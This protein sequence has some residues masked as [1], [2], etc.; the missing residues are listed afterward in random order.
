MMEPCLSRADRKQSMSFLGLFA[1]AIASSLGWAAREG[2]RSGDGV[3]DRACRGETPFRASRWLSTSMLPLPQAPLLRLSLLVERNDRGEREAVARRPTKGLLRS[4]KRRG[5]ASWVEVR[6][7]EG[8][9]PR[10]AARGALS[11]DS[12][13]PKSHVERTPRPVHARWFR[14]CPRL[15]AVC[16]ASS[17]MHWP[18]SEHCA[19]YAS[20]AGGST[21]AHHPGAAAR[22]VERVP[23]LLRLPQP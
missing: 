9:K 22:S 2:R 13:R 16:A 7:G 18:R 1:S 15:L 6:D 11:L 20:R 23:V 19:P 3:G 17:R 8:P 4:R 12:Q 14:W 5:C 10:T 21:H